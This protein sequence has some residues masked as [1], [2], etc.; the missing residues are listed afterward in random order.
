MY[1]TAALLDGTPGPPPCR[2]DFPEEVELVGGRWRDVS[3]NHAQFRALQAHV[4]GAAPGGVNTLDAPL[5]TLLGHPPQFAFRPGTPLGYACLLRQGSMWQ[6]MVG[7]KPER[8]ACNLPGP[9]TCLAWSPTGRFLALGAADTLTL[10]ETGTW[11]MLR[12]LRLSSIEVQTEATAIELESLAWLQPN[13]ILVESRLLQ[14]K[15]LT[16]MLA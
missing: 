15:E 6:G 11:T 1:S 14:G 10:V 12:T 3:G 16:W 2:I 9:A 4:G 7:A 13:R 8:L 5:R